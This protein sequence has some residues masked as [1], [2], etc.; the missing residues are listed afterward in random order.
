MLRTIQEIHQERETG[1]G[2]GNMNGNRGYQFPWKLHDMLQEAQKLGKQA[3]VSF[4][5]H[6]KAFRVHNKELF[7]VEIMPLFFKQSKYKSFQRQLHLW[8]FKRILEGPD[9]GAYYHEAFLKGR[10]NLC[11][12]MT[13]QKVKSE[14]V[15]NE[16][17]E[18]PNVYRA[19]TNIAMQQQ[20]N[21]AIQCDSLSPALGAK[22]EPSVSMALAEALPVPNLQQ[23]YTPLPSVM[24]PFQQKKI[25]M[26][27]FGPPSTDKTSA[28]SAAIVDHL[29]VDMW[30]SICLTHNFA[31]FSIL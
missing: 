7:S 6:G 9:E 15:K 11:H 31:F 21:Q 29:F 12:Y 23:I 26:K 1:T 19:S 20:H 16:N 3:I 10:P 25:E 17:Q 2:S 13:R 5:S 8:G 22:L 24:I 30:K 18:V 14:T 27:A 28:V 4:Q